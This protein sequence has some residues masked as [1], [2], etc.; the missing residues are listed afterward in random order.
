MS[1]WTPDPELI[2]PAAMD[3]LERELRQMAL[4]EQEVHKLQ[5]E[6]MQAEIAR[7]ADQAQYT[8]VDGLGEVEFETDMDT[9]LYWE[10]KQP[11]CWDDPQFRREFVRDNP[12]ARPPK[13]VTS[14]TSVLVA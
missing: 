7:H 6:A 3:R 13:P 11:G 10:I 4:R 8:M 5:Q 9:Y 14:H 1:L 12:G 2:G